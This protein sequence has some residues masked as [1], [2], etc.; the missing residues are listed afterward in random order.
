MKRTFWQII[1]TALLLRRTLHS[2]SNQ[3]SFKHSRHYNKLR[4]KFLTSEMDSSSFTVEDWASSLD[5]FLWSNCTVSWRDLYQIV[6]ESAIRDYKVDVG[7]ITGRTTINL[8]FIYCFSAIFSLY[9]VPVPTGGAFTILLHTP[10][11][12]VHFL[13]LT[14]WCFHRELNSGDHPPL[15]RKDS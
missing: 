4:E 7:S 15:L 2:F 1:S 12:S 11:V 3:G 14:F 8:L 5:C 10:G 6:T 13:A 9:S